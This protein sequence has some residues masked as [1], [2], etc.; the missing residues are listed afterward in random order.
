MPCGVTVGEF[1]SPGCLNHSLPVVTSTQACLLPEGTEAGSLSY[2]FPAC[3]SSGPCSPACG[4]ML[5]G[6]S[7]PPKLQHLRPL[8]PLL[9]PSGTATWDT[10][11][12]VQLWSE[13]CLSDRPKLTEICCFLN[14]KCCQA[15]VCTQRSKFQF[16]VSTE[17]N[18]QKD[19]YF[20]VAL[21]PKVLNGLEIN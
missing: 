20:S 5:T 19:R 12:L 14:D 13:M 8:V 16:S 9:S 2:L 3:V 18:I 11:F 15:C 4:L 10:L 21:F 1:C 17:S 7:M 6:Q